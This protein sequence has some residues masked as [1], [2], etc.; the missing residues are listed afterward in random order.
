MI[1]C[2]RA[3]WQEQWCPIAS[4]I[5]M[6]LEEID[7]SYALCDKVLVVDVGCDL[8]GGQDMCLHPRQSAGAGGLTAFAS[9]CFKLVVDE[10]VA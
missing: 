6:Q 10:K 5:R 7:V 1:S 3:R 8:L 2:T 4:I 9:I